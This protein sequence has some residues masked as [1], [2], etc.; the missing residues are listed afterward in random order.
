MGGA[1]EEEPGHVPNLRHQ[2]LQPARLHIE[3]PANQIVFREEEE[4]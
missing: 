3:A 4:P 1:T 2:E